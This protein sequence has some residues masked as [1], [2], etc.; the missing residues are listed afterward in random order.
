M[1]IGI[2][3]PRTA[4]PIARSRIRAAFAPMSAASQSAR[5]APPS[6]ERNCVPSSRSGVDPYI[7]ADTSRA[8]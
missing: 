8:R 6:A 7:P 1:N 5:K 2:I 4:A 3:Q